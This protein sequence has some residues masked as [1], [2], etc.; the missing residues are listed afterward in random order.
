MR[1]LYSH[2][3]QSR[4]GQSVHVE[5]MVAALRQA[6][7]EVLV[8][9]PGF[10][11]QAEFG[12]ESRLVAWIR[13]RLPAA[14]GELAEVAYNVPAY[15]RLRR[16]AHSFHPDIIYERY[17]LYYLAGA[18][19][20]RRLGVPFYLEVNAPIADERM[21]FSGLRLRGLARRLEAWT[22]RAATRVIA[23][24]G[25]LKSMITDAGVAS[26]RI[27]VVPNG[28]DPAAFADLPARPVAPDP[29]VLGFVGF[30][31]DWH[32][33]D[34]VIAAMAEHAGAPRLDLVVVGDGPARAALE[35]QAA[36]LGI[37]D[38]VRFTGLAPHADVP[39]M[40]AG[41]DIALQPRAVAYASPLKLFDYMAAGR[42]IVAPDQANIREILT[43]RET[44]L[45]FDPAR[46]DAV[47]LAVLRLTGDAGLRGRLGA[48]ARAEIDRRRYTWAG[49]AARLVDWAAHDMSRWNRAE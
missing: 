1:I 47:W 48:A 38:C 11:Q 37:A 16:A 13:A 8:V 28:I 32:G 2:R 43:D 17:N 44:A 42:A 19:L 3:I 20:A 26:E 5:Q 27:E 30:V 39:R 25:V 40:V 18:L 9:G 4:D 45:L 41:F 7:H 21:R 22:W 10:Y 12:A 24:T 31:R 29:L 6:G 46:P 14:L 15:R 35:R 23:V 34:A 33:L 36:A 49:N